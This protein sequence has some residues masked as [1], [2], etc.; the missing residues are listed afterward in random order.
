[1]LYFNPL[2]LNILSFIFFFIFIFYKSLLHIIII[3]KDIYFIR[4]YYIYLNFIIKY[5]IKKELKNML[6][7]I[8]FKIKIYEN[9]EIKYDMYILIMFYNNI[10]NFN[11]YLNVIF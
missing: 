10:I 7:N 9:E 8:K 5:Y 3:L 4:F 11:Y 2:L 1:M 6:N